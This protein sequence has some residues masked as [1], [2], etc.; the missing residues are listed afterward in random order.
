MTSSEIIIEFI[1]KSRKILGHQEKEFGPFFHQ[2]L[3][4]EMPFK[5]FEENIRILAFLEQSHWYLTIEGRDYR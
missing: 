1:V 5:I 4:N 3:P 2:W